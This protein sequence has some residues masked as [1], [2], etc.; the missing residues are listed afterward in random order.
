MS[1]GGGLAAVRSPEGQPSERLE[2]FGP[3]PLS[4]HELLSLV[5]GSGNRAAPAGGLA[6]RVLDLSGG[7]LRDL[8]QMDAGRL[9]G[10]PGIGPAMAA[11]I[12]A[13]IE[14]GKRIGSAR[15]GREDPITGP[16]DVH[17]IFAPGLA[18]LAHEEFHVLL[19]NSQNVPICQRQVTRGILDASLIHPREV[20][21]DAIV[22]RAAAVIL[23]HNHP[24][25]NPE[26]SVEDLKVTRQLGKAGEQLGI[27][28]LDHI[29]VAGG[30]FSSLAGRGLLRGADGLG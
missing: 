20:F 28:V 24:S 21:R 25:G 15:A 11:R 18:H 7:H 27:P 3:G 12:V 5:I 23:V 4:E 6:E 8:A 17:D 1:R 19:L 10:I 2:R 29:I 30:T 22:L 13:A 26:P 14:L 9:V 16:G